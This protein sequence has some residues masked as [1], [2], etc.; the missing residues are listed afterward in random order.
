MEP[1]DPVL[2]R[3]LRW[4]GQPTTPTV[5]GE[6]LQRAGVGVLACKHTGLPFAQDFLA[7]GGRRL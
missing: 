2:R 3:Q 7:A 4:R 6:W 1:G 5:V